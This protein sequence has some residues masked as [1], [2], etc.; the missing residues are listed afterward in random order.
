MLH[1]AI[2]GFEDYL[3][4][5]T[6]QVYSIKS[7]KY[8]KATKSCYGYLVVTLYKNGKGLMK[9]IHR[10]VA[11][12]FI[13]NPDNKPTVDHINRNKTDNRVSNLRWADYSEQIRNQS[14]ELSKHVNKVNNGKP[15]TMKFDNEISMSFLSVNSIK[16][17]NR[18]TINNHRYKG[19]THFTT[20][21]VEF[22]IAKEDL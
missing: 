10:L 21:G 22:F 2:K 9:F 14:H 13:K 19:E 16:T 15:I 11:E 1:K 3:I 6:G 12:V 4:S 18:S 7:K 17:V 20:K 8:M 5:D